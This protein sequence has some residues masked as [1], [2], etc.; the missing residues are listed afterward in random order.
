LNKETRNAGEKPVHGFMGSL[1]KPK[2]RTPTAGENLPLPK[3]FCDG[4]QGQ[5]AF[6]FNAIDEKYS[7]WTRSL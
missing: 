1:L 2:L 3:S 4:R 6:E 7:S 5:L